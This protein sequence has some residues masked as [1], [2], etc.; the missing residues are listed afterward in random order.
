MIWG[1]P[2]CWWRAEPPEM[3]GLCKAW[4]GISTWWAQ[5]LLAC[6]ALLTGLAPLNIAPRCSTPRPFA[7]LPHDPFARRWIERNMV[8]RPP[9]DAGSI[10]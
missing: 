9:L 7:A 4:D 2:E 10:L 8:C 6:G 3:E 1:S 5:T